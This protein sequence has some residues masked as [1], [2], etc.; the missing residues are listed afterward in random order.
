MERELKR[1][2]LGFHKNDNAFLAVNDGAA[3]QAAF[4]RLSPRIIRKQLDYSALILG[5]KLSKKE[6]T[7][8]S[9]SRF[10][11]IAQIE[12]CDF[13]PRNKTAVYVPAP[14]M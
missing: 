1:S 12:Y 9:L 8:M 11:S 4:G 10:Y 5:P 3:L 2:N 6:R 13:V 14:I 7:Q